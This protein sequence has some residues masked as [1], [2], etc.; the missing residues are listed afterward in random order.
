MTICKKKARGQTIWAGTKVWGPDKFNSLLTKLI[1][2]PL[3]DYLVGSS[4]CNW[5]RTQKHLV[6]EHSTIWLDWFYLGFTYC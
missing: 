6:N 2:V 1:Y 3:K 5:T 4:Y